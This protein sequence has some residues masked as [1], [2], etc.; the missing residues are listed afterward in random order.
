MMI[1]K[2]YDSYF[3]MVVLGSES[4]D[5]NIIEGDF[6]KLSAH[7]ETD[8]KFFYLFNLVCF[9]LVSTYGIMFEQTKVGNR[10]KTNYWFFILVHVSYGL[11]A[12]TNRIFKSKEGNNMKGEYPFFS[13]KIL[14]TDVSFCI[15]YVIETVPNG[16]TL[17]Q[18][19][20]CLVMIAKIYDS[21]FSPWLYWAWNLRMATSLKVIFFSCQLTSKLMLYLSICSI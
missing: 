4:Q 2:I 18:F 19:K 3:A 11:E 17:K 8:T 7:F 16:N 13:F 10:F 20:V 1:V 12:A 6:L 14:V 5:G 9:L 21:S 15:F